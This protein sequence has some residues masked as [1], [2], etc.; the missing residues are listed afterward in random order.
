[1]SVAGSDVLAGGGCPG[2]A[3]A[4]VDCATKDVAAT[5]E[6]ASGSQ[7][8]G[9]NVFILMILGDPVCHVKGRQLSLPLKP[10]KSFD[11]DDSPTKPA[12]IK[13]DFTRD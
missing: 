2:F 1:L 6:A 10:L 5:R 8:D 7:I 4:F 9:D 3:G 11:A 13:D 12:Y